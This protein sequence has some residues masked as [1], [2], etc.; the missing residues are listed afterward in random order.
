MNTFVEI[1]ISFFSNL[2]IHCKLENIRKICLSLFSF[3]NKSDIPYQLKLSIYNE[4]FSKNVD[5]KL[6][7][8]DTT[9]ETIKQINVMWKQILFGCR[10]HFSNLRY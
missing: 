8:H 3:Y 2:H 4:T 9:L 5:I 7:E 6:S 1:F 10:E